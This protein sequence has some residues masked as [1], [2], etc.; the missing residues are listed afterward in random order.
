M[1]VVFT[2]HDAAYQGMADITRPT[3]ER[4]ALKHGYDFVYDPNVNETEKDA[5]KARLF[6]QLFYS[7]RY[8]VQDIALWVDTD[9]AILNPNVKMDDVFY[10]D[11]PNPSPHFV[12]AY[13]WNGPN[14]GVWMA[15][16]TSQAAHFIRTYDYLARA[17]GWGDNWAMNQTMLLPPFNEYVR[18]VSGKRMNSNLYDLHGLQNMDHKY[19]V[20][21]YAPGDWILHLAGLETSLRMKVLR[22]RVPGGHAYTRTLHRGRDGRVLLEQWLIHGAGHAWSGGSAAGSFTDPLGPDASREMLRFF[23]QHA[24]QDSPRLNRSE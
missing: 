16:F 15:R 19:M 20:N 2:A 21:A 22:E 8:G 13:D 18:C 6:L 14:S 11:E 12:W 24:K 7:G 3:L 17:M 23:E 1:N 5:C 9:A 4:Y 10:E